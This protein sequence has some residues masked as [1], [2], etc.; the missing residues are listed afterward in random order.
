M[1]FKKFQFERPTDGVL[2][3]STKTILTE[4]TTVANPTS[5]SKNGQNQLPSILSFVD[6][7]SIVISPTH[8]LTYSYLNVPLFL[9][10][11]QAYVYSLEDKDIEEEEAE[12][13]GPISI[14]SF[15]TL[16]QISCRV[17]SLYNPHS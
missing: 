10:N 12:E 5:S 16:Q 9:Y 4:S 2:H 15:F 6:S 1:A 3:T 14:I 7:F 17:L 8:T 13:D 11:L